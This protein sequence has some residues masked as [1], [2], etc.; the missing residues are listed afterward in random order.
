MSRRA[1]EAAL[2]VGDLAGARSALVGA[3]RAAP[4]DVALRSFLFQL[5]CVTGDWDRAAK[6][7]DVVAQ[8]DP[9]A[10]DLASDYRAAIAAE[11]V[12]SNVFAGR[13]R[14]AIFGATAPWLDGMIAALA[15]DAAGESDAAADARAAA[16]EAAPS[17][18]GEIDGAPFAWLADADTRL[19]PVLE[20]V[21]NGAYR[22][23]PFAE[24]A[25][26]EVTPPTDLRDAVWTVAMLTVTGGGEWPVL[27]PTRYPGS[28]A[29]PDAAIALARRTE[30]IPLGGDHAAGL[31]QRLLAHDR[32]D[33]ALLDLR[34]LSFEAAGAEG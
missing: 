1:A 34:A 33:V 10:M 16:L 13:A 18:A 14:P 19:G 7:L 26:L 21:M 27:I 20:V 28:E 24:I 25:R 15:Q 17:R 8:L 32:G 12:R 3:I 6:Q 9:A 23:L 11:A 30:W 22:W 4:G 31:G 29:S 2:A 5:S